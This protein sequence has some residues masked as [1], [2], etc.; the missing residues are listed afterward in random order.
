MSAEELR[1]IIATRLEKSGSSVGTH[2]IAN[3]LGI[4]F[5]GIHSDDQKQQ[6]EALN[7]AGYSDPQKLKEDSDALVK[8]LNLSPEEYEH[9]FDPSF[10]ERLRAR[11]RNENT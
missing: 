8:S 10:T 6:R 3:R 11:W 2:G 4:I 1:K 7:I 9:Y 5:V